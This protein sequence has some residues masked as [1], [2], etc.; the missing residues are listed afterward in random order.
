MVNMMMS[1]AMHG[2][3]FTRSIN[4]YKRDAEH[5]ASFADYEVWLQNFGSIVH[6]SYVCTCRFMPVKDEYKKKMHTTI[7]FSFP[8]QKLSPGL[9]L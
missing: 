7:H 6:R 3:Q 2:L 8:L 1:S 4:K 5:S 9:E